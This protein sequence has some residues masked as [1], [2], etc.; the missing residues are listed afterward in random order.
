MHMTQNKDFNNLFFVWKTL[1]E[2]FSIFN[3]FTTYLIV[4]NGSSFYHL[5]QS[6]STGFDVYLSNDFSQSKNYIMLLCVF[7]SQAWHPSWI[8]VSFW[9]RSM[10]DFKLSFLCHW[11]KAGKSKTFCS[12]YEPFKIWVLVCFFFLYPKVAE[13][14]M[15]APSVCS[16]IMILAQF[17]TLA[18]NWFHHKSMKSHKIT[19]FCNP[20]VL[21]P[22]DHVVPP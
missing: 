22:W 18:S 20:G 21:L 19:T 13:W 1:V 4:T 9:L 6:Q 3:S 12:Y 2:T 8:H 15:L 11:I 10:A 7:V 17:Y 14:N 16:H 5:R